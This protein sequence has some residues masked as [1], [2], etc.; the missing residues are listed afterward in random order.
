MYLHVMFTIDILTI[1]K[2]RGQVAKFDS[3]FLM[4]RLI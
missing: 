4:T 2:Y 3:D 1:V